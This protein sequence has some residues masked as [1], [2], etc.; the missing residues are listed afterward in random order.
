MTEKVNEHPHIGGCVL[1]A[2]L[3]TYGMTGQSVYLEQSLPF[4]RDM[5]A[6]F[7][8]IE[9][10]VISRTCEASRFLLPLALACAYSGEPE[11]RA[12]LKEQADFLRAHTAPCGAIQEAGSNLGASVEGADLGLANDKRDTISDQLYCTGFA[13]MNFWIAY[14][15]TGDAAYRE[16]FFRIADYL[17]RIQ[18][19]TPDPATDGGWMRGFDYGLW[20]YYG[21]NADQFWT[22]YCMETGWCNAIIDIALSLYL[23]DDSFFEPRKG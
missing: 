6:R 11:F 9:S 16:D 19:E 21:S 14:K 18:A 5:I 12:A 10:Y 1:S 3:Y 15:A 22:A 20:E 8:H 4:L 23:L 2:W 17:V 13:A 7:P